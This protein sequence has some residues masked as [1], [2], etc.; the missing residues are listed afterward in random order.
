MVSD[1]LKT[2]ANDIEG[3]LGI[4]I[5]KHD[6]W[7]IE[8]AAVHGYDAEDPLTGA[9]TTPIYQAITFSHP[10]FEGTKGFGYTR[11]GNPTVLELENT[12]AL[13]EGGKKAFAMASGMAAITLV[14]KLF[15]AGDHI[16]VGDDMYG[17]TYMLF[18]TIYSRY[19]LEFDYVDSSN[20]DELARAIK[21]NTKAI[22]VETPT[23]PT[24]KVVDIAAAAAIAHDAGALLVVD[25]TLMTSYFQKPF[26]LGA[27]LVVYSGS[28]YLCGHNDVMC[29]FVVVRDEELIEP[30]YNGYKT[31]GATLPPFD[32]WLMQRSLKTLPLRLRAQQENALAITA[33][34]KEHPH[35]TD[36]LYVG[37]PEHPSYELTCKQS[38]GFGGM[39]SFRTDTYERMQQV[40]ERV[41][42]I[43]YAESLGGAESLI[44]Y[45][46]VRTHSAMPEELLAR[47]GIDDRLLRLSVGFESANDLIADLEQALA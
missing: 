39:I 38:S 26:E 37:D 35:V 33:F 28:K 44:T 47:L 25:N 30:I 15:S 24:M 31:E 6:D 13:L 9:I 4:D 16:V 22:F 19:G 45:P 5:N 2:L 1:A 27:D 7:S 17:G 11:T 42:L 23:N 12:I 3:L 8:T 43:T 14:L 36:V 29:G 32:C 41:R 34:L 20:T 46:K 40:V 10:A 18:D 21:P